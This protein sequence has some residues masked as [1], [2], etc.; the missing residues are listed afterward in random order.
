MLHPSSKPVQA[1]VA[2]TVVKKRYDL[3]VLVLALLSCLM[4]Q[5]FRAEF[6]RW[7][8]GM[9]IEFAV[10]LAFPCLLLWFYRRRFYRRKEGQQDNDSNHLF[11]LAQ[12]IALFVVLATIGWQMA[13]RW[14]GAGDSIEVAALLVLQ[15]TCWFVSV[16]SFVRG[17]QKAALLLSGSLVFF[18]SCIGE[19]MTIFILAGIYALVLLWWLSEFYWN[20]LDSKAIDGN[21]RMLP[22]R[23][24]AIVI[25]SLTIGGTAAVVSQASFLKN[26]LDVAGM[27]PF[28]G[29]EKG[30]SD[31][32]ARGGFGDGSMLAAGQNAKTTGA[33]DSNQFIEDQKE[34]M[35]DVSLERFEGP[36]FKRPRNRSVTLDTIAKHM[37]GVKQSEQSGRTFRTMR[38]SEEAIE[39]EFEN[40]ETTALFFVEGSVPVRFPIDCF[41]QFDGWDWSKTEISDVKND[42]LPRIRLQKDDDDGPVYQLIRARSKYLSDT[43]MHRIK[44]MRLKTST[45]PG[46]SLLERWRIA[47]VASP[48]LFRWNESGLVRIDSESFAS[49]TVIDTESLIP[50]F[51][52][53]RSSASTKNR[54]TGLD[55]Q[56]I[57]DSEY[58]QVPDNETQERLKELVDQWSGNSSPGWDQ[59]DA[60]VKQLKANYELRP[61]WTVDETAEDT[62]GHFLEQGG[63]P[64]YMFATTCVMMLRAAGYKTR[65]ARG[66]LVQKE[67][68]DRVA[69]QS[70]VGSDNLHM[71]PEVSLDERHWIPVEPTPGY[72][73]VYNTQT[74]QQ[75]LSSSF[76]SVVNWLKNNPWTSSLVLLVSLLTLVFRVQLL[77]G[78]MLGWWYLVRLFR[79]TRLLQATRQLIDFRFWAASKRRPPAETIRSW[80]CQI[81]PELCPEFFDLW[82]ERNYSEGSGTVNRTEL[83]ASCLQPIKTLTTRNIKR[84]I[85]QQKIKNDDSRDCS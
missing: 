36:V 23:T 13:L 58:L 37:H 19:N 31:E 51:H 75:W 80:Y 77:S 7:L 10:V 57:S 72:P 70:V 14:I 50:N 49:Q 1:K 38:E 54:F 45:L 59:V 35:Y 15:N 33:V 63:G 5:I 65:L 81:E 48:D 53:M 78:L 3:T 79:P 27:L 9:W 2:G 82:D 83:V 84:F 34:S 64:S 73:E 24:W 55:D 42:R 60:I 67:D 41:D 6:S 39:G 46:P 32:F 25:T 4:L 11:Y 17:F 62:V 61:N 21:S 18:V 74:F 29:G 44:V 71:W 30:F 43:R 26:Q 69:R 40:K 22:I 52:A 47:H 8:A 12:A 16:F 66:F 68:Y 20:R 76:L 28:S 56:S 85:T